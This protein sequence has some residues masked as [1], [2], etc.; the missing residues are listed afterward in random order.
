MVFYAVFMNNRVVSLVV[1]S[2]NLDHLRPPFVDFGPLISCKAL[3]S[4]REVFFLFD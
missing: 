2:L 4:A 1:W 3:K